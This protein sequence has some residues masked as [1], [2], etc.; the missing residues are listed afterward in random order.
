VLERG[1]NPDLGNDI[2]PRA[3]GG[4]P[5]GAGGKGAGGGG[6]DGGVLPFTGTDPATVT[7]VGTGLIATG[8]GLVHASRKKEKHV[9]GDEDDGEE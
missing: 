9:R 8:A 2:R 3:A 7:A 6:N 4:R 1:P 5:G